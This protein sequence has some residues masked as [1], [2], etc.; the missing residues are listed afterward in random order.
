MK[1]CMCCMRDYGEDG[2]QCPLCGYSEVQMKNDIREFPEALYPE[3]ILAGRFILGRA[4]SINDFSIIYISWDALLQ[5][6]VVVRE[7]FPFGLGIRRAGEPEIL[8]ENEQESL[9]FERGR[10]IFEREAKLLN[11]NQDIEGII[12]IYR[13]IRENNTSYAVMEYLEGNTLQDEMDGGETISKKQID[14]VIYEIAGII[15]CFHSRGISHYNLN[16]ENIFR[17][18]AGRIRITDFGDAKRE[19]YRMLDRN[20]NILDLRY[21][22]PEVLSGETAG[23]KSDLYS[24]G[25][26]YYRM[27]VGKEPPLSRTRRKKKRGFGAGSPESRII[28]ALTNPVLA[29]RPAEAAKALTDPSLA[30]RPEETEKII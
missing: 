4:L 5:R 15:D 8:F 19:V 18:D 11:E 2:Q 10:E 13:V 29:M 1:K 21:T 25:A 9:L 22:A 26:I 3:T 24:L 23:Y 17:D 28:E 6:R 16:P 14:A 7:Y 27:L 20:A 30:M 12:H